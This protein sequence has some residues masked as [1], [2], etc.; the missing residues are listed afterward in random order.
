[1]SNSRLMTWRKPSSTYIIY[2][3]LEIAVGIMRVLS[4]G[5]VGMAWDMDFI[6]WVSERRIRKCMQEQEIQNV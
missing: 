2:G 1:M 5:S 6:F 3:V 4:L